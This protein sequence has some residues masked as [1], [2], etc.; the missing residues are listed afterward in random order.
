MET[1]KII[2]LLNA[3]S[4]EQSKF[5]KNKWY[6]IDNQTGR[7]GKYNE[8]SSIKFETSTI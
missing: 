7:K 3:A 5:A 8:N 2:D 1:Q 4:N 6:V